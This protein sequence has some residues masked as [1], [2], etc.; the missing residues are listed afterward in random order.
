VGQLVADA[1]ARRFG[2]PL[3]ADEELVQILY[4]AAAPAV[5]LVSDDAAIRPIK[6]QTF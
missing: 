3:V 4:D 5:E 6:V 1:F 2:T